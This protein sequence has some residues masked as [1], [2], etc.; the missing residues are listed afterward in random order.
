MRINQQ[1]TKFM[2]VNGSSESRAPLIVGDLRVENCE[3]YVYL[4]AVFTQD[5]K[6]SSSI[7]LHCKDKYKHV[8]KFFSFIAKNFNFPFW[9]KRKV[10]EAALLSA[11]LYSCESWLENG[12][13][14]LQKL[15]TSLVKALLGVRVSSPNDLCLLELGIP[16]V[17][18]RIR[19]AQKRF[20]SKMIVDRKVDDPFAFVWEMCT[21]SKTRAAKYVT[22]L[23]NEE[24]I[25]DN[26]M[27][28]IRWRVVNNTG[29]KF[30][31]YV[32]VNPELTPH[33]LYRFTGPHYESDRVIFTRLRLLSHDLAIEKGRW[34]RIPREN[35]LCPCG[36]VQTEEHIVCYCNQSA[37]VRGQ[38][39]NINFQ[40]LCEFFDHPNLSELSSVCGAIYGQYR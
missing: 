30:A 9:V 7:N 12:L 23:L 17:V 33:P 19:Q 32:N 18:G 34:S 15:Y 13:G 40:S 36:H 24:N 27:D 21:N 29:S 35:R 26:D 3:S 4:G 14:D 39:L 25:I 38:H 8:L 31:M 10:F 5:G 11:V 20:F 2:C 6:T 1:K 37:H 16:S 22:N 28:T